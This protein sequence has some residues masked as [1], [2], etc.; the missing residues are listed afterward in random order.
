MHIG[1]IDII[2]F[3]LLKDLP[4]VVAKVQCEV[5]PLRRSQG[6]NSGVTQD[7]AVKELTSVSR[8]LSILVRAVLICKVGVS[9]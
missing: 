3:L 7:V 8:S 1:L 6:N 4:E 5:D 9:S 2:V